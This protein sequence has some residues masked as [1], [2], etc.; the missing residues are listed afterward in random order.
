[1]SAGY[2]YCAHCSK[3]RAACLVHI[4]ADGG[5]LVNRLDRAAC[6]VNITADGGSLVDSKDRAAYLVHISADGGSLVNSKDRAAC[7]VHISA[8]GGLPHILL[9]T[10]KLQGKSTY[11]FSSVLHIY[12]N[13]I[14]ILLSLLI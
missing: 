1:V 13:L 8:D 6:L 11:L 3:D 4:S 7:L 2:T 10:F 12:K 5:S 9:Q 14:F